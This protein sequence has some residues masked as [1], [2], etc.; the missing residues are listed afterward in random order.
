MA[1]VYATLFRT[2][3]DPVER[4]RRPGLL[5]AVPLG[6]LALGVLA[7]Q[8][9]PL[10]FWR[11]LA[12]VAA[13]HF[14]RQPWGWMSYSARRAGETSRLDRRLDALAI[15]AA[16]IYPLVWWHAH[17]PRSFAWFVEGDFASG[18]PSG[19]LPFAM[20]AH[21]LILGAWG[22]RQIALMAIGRAI[23]LGKLLILASTWLAWNAGI[24]WIDGDFVFTATNVLAH[25]VPYTAVVHRW[26]RARFEGQEGLVAS[27]FRPGRALAYLGAL[28]AVALLE[29]GIW[30][31]VVWHE[32]G[33]LFPLPAIAAPDGVLAFVVPL[34][35]VPQATHYVLDAFLWRT[36]KGNPGLAAALRLD[37]PPAAA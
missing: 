28:V 5:M 21:V 25:G 7:Y 36:R 34:L 33:G 4:R 27:L 15:H 14:V 3:L 30:D 22:A 37:A 2:Y 8:V 26:G 20:W 11:G 29:E 6:A 13:F 32:H 31:R 9:S 12:Y 18:L 23:N 19:A 35:A 16:T 1:H 10:A 17:L 24:V